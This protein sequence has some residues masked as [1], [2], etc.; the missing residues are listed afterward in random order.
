MAQCNFLPQ[1]IASLCINLQRVEYIGGPAGN[2]LAAEAIRNVL[3]ARLAA[4]E[5]AQAILQSLTAA[6]AAC[7]TGSS[8]PLILSLSSAAWEALEEATQGHGPKQKPD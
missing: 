3:M 4:L 2:D 5:A 7:L 1:T 8:V 6:A